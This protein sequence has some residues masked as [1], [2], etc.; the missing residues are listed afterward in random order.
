[1][2]VE[3]ISYTFLALIGIAG[4]TETGEIDPLVE[5]GDVAKEFDIH[6]HVDAAWGGGATMFSEKHK[7]K[8]KGIESADSITMCG[9]KQLYTYLRE[10][11]FACLK[12]RKC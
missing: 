3:K 6:F 11:V 1:M 9:H 12:I 8:L 10:S 7:G 4:T 2:T 5:M